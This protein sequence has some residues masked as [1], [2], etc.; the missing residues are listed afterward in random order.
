MKKLDYTKA[1][2]FKKP[3]KGEENLIFHIENYNEETGRC[4]I[5]PVKLEGWEGAVMP[6]E[7][8]SMDDLE[9]I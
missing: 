1:V 8:V 3:G 6:S 4:Y 7:L 2:R 9:N 5:S